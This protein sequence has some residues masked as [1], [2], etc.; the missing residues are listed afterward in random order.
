MYN[1]TYKASLFL[2]EDLPSKLQ[3]CDLND[4]E[5][6]EELKYEKSDEQDNNNSLKKEEIQEKSNL[7]N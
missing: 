5:E 4:N 2:D 1:P 3:E 6:E 7:S